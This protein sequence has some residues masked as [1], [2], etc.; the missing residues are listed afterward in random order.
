METFD[1]KKK[2][3]RQKWV[4][5]KASLPDHNIATHRPSSTVS[6][7]MTFCEVGQGTGRDN[8]EHLSEVKIG[9]LVTKATIRAERQGQAI[10]QVSLT[11]RAPLLGG[12]PSL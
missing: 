8:G 1:R 5:Y 10:A 11:R 12:D 3:K 2:K 4:T 7:Q 9:S 6:N